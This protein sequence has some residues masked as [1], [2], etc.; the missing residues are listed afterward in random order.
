MRIEV[1]NIIQ[2]TLII[3]GLVIIL[4][5]IYLKIYSKQIEKNAVDTFEKKIEEKIEAEEINIGDEIALINIPSI[6]LN[7]AIIH[8]TDNKYLKHHVCH[9][10]NSAMPGENGNFAIAGHSSYRYNQVFNDIHKVNIGDTIKIKTINE[11]F[12]YKITKK[13]ETNPDNIEVLNQ[14]NHIKEITIVTCTNGG[15]DRLIIKGLI[16]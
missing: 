16:E 8:G 15:K 11:E 2:K 7:T 14:D 3:L 13:F 5:S 9:F 12:T 4:G 1:K 6:N 10:E